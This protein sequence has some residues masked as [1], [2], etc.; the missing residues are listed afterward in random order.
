MPTSTQKVKRSWLIGGAVLVGALAL[1][2]PSHQ[3]HAG[4]GLFDISGIVGGAIGYVAYAL[5]FIVSIITGVV[6]ALVTYLISVILYLSNNVV[7]TFA[8]QSGYSVT[9]A[10]ANL[11]FVLAIIIIAIATILKRETYGIKKTLWMLVVAAILVNFSLIIGGVIINFANTLTNTFLPDQSPYTFATDLAGAFSPQRA[12]LNINVSG[13]NSISGSVAGTSVAAGAGSSLASILTPLVSVSC[14]VGFLIVIVIT[15][16]TFLFMLLIRYVYLSI[17]LVLMPFAWLMW[18]FPK[19]SHLWNNWWEKFLKWTFFSPIV[20][21]FLYLAIATAQAMNSQSANDP[22]AFIKGSTYQASASGIVGGLSTFFG[23]FVGS[24]A[25]TIL[26]GVIVIGLA[27]GGMIA[28]E[29]FSIMGSK[30]AMGAMTSM[31]NAAKGYAGKQT[32][33]GGRWAYQRAGGARLNAGLQRSRIPFASALGRGLE[34]VTEKGGKNLVKEA[35]T[36][37]KLGDMSNEKLAMAAQG[38]R[39]SENTLAIIAEA[40]KRGVLNKLGKVGG[41][42]DLNAWVGKNQR[43]FEDYDHGKLKG[44]VNFALGSD[45]RMRRIAQTQGEAR[46][47]AQVVDTNGILGAAGAQVS[48]EQLIEGSG[49]AKKKANDAI[50]RDGP[51]AV[52]DHMGRRVSASTLATAAENSSRTANDAL[53]KA[54]DEVKVADVA[55]KEGK[56]L[57]GGP[58]GEMVKAA[59]LMR[60]AAEKFFASVDKT[61]ASKF[62]LEQIFGGK[63]NFGLSKE[64]IDALSKGVA[65]GIA[66][67]TPYLMPT[68]T[69]KLDSSANFQRFFDR[70]IAAIEQARRE[71]KIDA[72]KADKLTEAI[73][74]TMGNRL[75]WDSGATTTTAAGPA[76]APSPAPGGT[77]PRP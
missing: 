47:G 16:T 52:V 21:F 12:L 18:L 63:P 7:N 11:G 27:I 30:A 28:A 33:K 64:A 72:E 59:D 69:G 51:N 6:I 76:P 1:L 43:V 36:N 2:L 19:T 74:S 77:P 3:A 44:D 45:E 42:A 58:A 40:Q 65:H 38:A 46:V 62:H 49:A 34:G 73:K 22:L 26:Q 35:A 15:L 29:K 8:V 32:K 17:L 24:F 13:G 53:N 70:Y 67:Q 10:I 55:D 66:I 5:I 41:E 48:A 20:V 57:M 75:V 71:R 39:G 60:A 56:T 4:L 68:M 54:A 37:L 14:A 50:D 23:S 9:L 31:G 25:T 61:D